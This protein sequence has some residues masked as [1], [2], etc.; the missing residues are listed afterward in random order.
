MQSM[1]VQPRVLA[2]GGEQFFSQRQASEQHQQQNMGPQVYSPK[3][4]RARMFPQGMPV[5]TI[6]GSVN[7]EMNNAYLLKQ[8]N[9]PL[10]TQQQQ[11]QQQQ[12]QHQT[13]SISNDMQVPPQ[14]S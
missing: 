10:L 8:K 11:Q 2:V 3:V 4:N 14:I 6:N 13:Q 12:Q 5:N 9:E 1:N 7:Q